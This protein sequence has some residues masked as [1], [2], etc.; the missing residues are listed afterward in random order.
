M[1]SSLTEEHTNNNSNSNSNNNSIY[2]QA[3][4]TT[5]TPLL[6]SPLSDEQATSDQLESTLVDILTP[7]SS[8]WLKALISIH[9]NDSVKV[10]LLDATQVTGAKIPVV[11]Q[12]GNI[13]NIIQ[14][15]P[16]SVLNQN[17]RHVHIL[18]T[19]TNGLGISIKGGKLNK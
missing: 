1:N 15:I 5:Q 19:E 11:Q 8:V 13:S 14:C 17:R 12:A 4:V 7:G 10:K 16:D 9:N 18:K 2:R 3:A 6:F